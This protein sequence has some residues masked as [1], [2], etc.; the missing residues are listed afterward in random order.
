MSISLSH[1]AWRM[2]QDSLY[3]GFHSSIGKS[4]TRIPQTEASSVAFPCA[5]IGPRIEAIYLVILLFLFHIMAV[6]VTSIHCL[7]CFSYSDFER[8]AVST[9]STIR[10]VYL[11]GFSADIYYYVNR[12]T[13]KS[14][15][16]AF[17]PKSRWWGCTSSNPYHVMWIIWHH[18]ISPLASCEF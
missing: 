7:S 18:T 2:D 1:E 14:P 12:Y 4:Y 9:A 5:R 11:S 3:S 16:L 8:S 13:L 10:Q 6:V 17:L 15:Y